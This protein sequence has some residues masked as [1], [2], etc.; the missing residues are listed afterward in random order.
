MGPS[1]LN[2]SLT[3]KTMI[4]EMVNYQKVN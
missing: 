3:L 4:G 2:T 1:Q